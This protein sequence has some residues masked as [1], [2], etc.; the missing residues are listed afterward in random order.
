V[1]VQSRKETDMI[2]PTLEELRDLAYILESTCKFE[3]VSKQASRTYYKNYFY[4]IGSIIEADG[5][6]PETIN[7]R[8]NRKAIQSSDNPRKQKII[9]KIYDLIYECSLEQLIPYLNTDFE[10]IVYWRYSL[11]GKSNE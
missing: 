8:I 6:S 1:E 4:I 10:P 9:R 3:Q 5:V 11:S 2:E 7:F